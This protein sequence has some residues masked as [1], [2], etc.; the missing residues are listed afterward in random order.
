MAKLS[1]STITYLDI[2]YN[3]KNI[4]NELDKHIVDWTYTDNLSGQIDDLQLTLEDVEN[5]WMNSWFPTKGALLE[6]SKCH[7]QDNGAIIRTMLGK[8]EVDEIDARG[9][10][11]Q[12]VIKALSTPEKSSLRGQEKSKAWEKATLKMVAGDIAKANGLKLVFKANETEKKDRIEQDQQ[13]DIAFLHEQCNSEGLCLKISN[14]AIVILDEAD[15]EDKPTVTTIYRDNKKVDAD[16]LVV[17][18]NA[19]TTLTGIYHSCTVKHKDTKSKK[20]IEGTYTPPKPP[21]TTR[22]L[23]EKEQVKSVA[24][25]Q[26]LAKKKLRQANKEATTVDLVIFSKKH[27]YAGQTVQL[28]QFGKFNGKYIISQTTYSNGNTSLKLRKCLVGY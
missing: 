13:T 6:V 15:Y 17:T 20:L 3:N 22:K 5:K 11:V 21:T 8:F 24:E 4:T 18:W 25:A 16:I 28:E 1:K 23:I 12:V 14:N 26:K 10:G 7:R 2:K 19:R 9:P 27:M